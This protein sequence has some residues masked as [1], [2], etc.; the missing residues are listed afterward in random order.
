MMT[1]SEVM[2]KKKAVLMCQTPLQALIAEKIIEKN[3]DTQFFPVYTAYEWNHK[4]EHYATRLLTTCQCGI[5]REMPT[6]AHIAQLTTEIVAMD[7]NDIYFASIDAPL[8]LAIL[9]AKENITI[10]TY[11]DGAANVTPKSIYLRKA[12]QPV[13]YPGLDI[14]WDKEKVRATSQKHYTIFNSTFNIVP[15]DKLVY[16]ELFP[17]ERTKSKTTYNKKVSVLIG[18]MILSPEENEQMMYRVMSEHNIDYYFPHPVEKTL[19]MISDKVIHTHLVFE[20]YMVTLLETYDE[21]AL[22][23]F[24]STVALNLK[25]HPRVKEIIIDKMYY[26]S[27][28]FTV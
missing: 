4:H 1:N 20:E 21:I 14:H 9:S 3:T 24:C 23:H 26:D 25:H 19:E 28:Y 27:W 16:V 12:K 5:K 22:Y 11:D 15:T 6:I 13:A 2:T 7:F 18:Q 10:Y 17:V 8:N